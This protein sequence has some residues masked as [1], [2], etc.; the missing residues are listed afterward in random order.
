MGMRRLLVTAAAA[1]AA[2]ALAAPPAHAVLFGSTLRAPANAGFGCESRPAERLFGGIELQPT[3]TA[4]CTWASAGIVGSLRRTFFVPRTGVIRSVSVRAGAN[5]APLRVTI[6]SSQTAVDRRGIAIGDPRPRPNR[7]T[8]VRVNLPVRVDA[9]D[10]LRST[11]GVGI[12]AVGP[13]TLPIA[14]VAPGSFDPG[15]PIASSW[16][17]RPGIGQPAG[18]GAGH[19]GFEVLLRA[20]WRPRR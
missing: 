15:S 13:G 14:A 16:H 20:D 5:P 3:G 17:P 8:T 1:L 7:V 18:S 9:D 6:L 11:D 19:V 4:T 10:G 12:T 2:A